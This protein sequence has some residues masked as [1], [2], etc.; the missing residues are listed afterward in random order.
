[1]HESLEAFEIC[2]ELNTDC[3]VSM[4]LASEKI[5]MDL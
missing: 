3:G 2:L 5:P 1:M 4:P